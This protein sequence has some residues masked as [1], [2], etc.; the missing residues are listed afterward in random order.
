MIQ[1]LEIQ[2][3]CSFFKRQT[4]VGMSPGEFLLAKSA[5]GASAGLSALSRPISWA[6]RGAPFSASSKLEKR[7]LP[8][9]FSN[10]RNILIKM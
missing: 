1:S 8:D 3:S 2:T 10:F 7:H 6:N 9:C 4:E 5:S